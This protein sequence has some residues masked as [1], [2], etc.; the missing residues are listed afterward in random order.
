MLGFLFRLTRRRTS[1][2]RSGYYKRSSYQIST[3]EQTEKSAAL[4]GNSIRENMHDLPNAQ[5]RKIIDGDTV[6]VNKAGSLIKVRLD[7]IDCPEDG[8]DWG[9]NAKYGLIKLIGGRSVK[10]EEH[11]ADH[12]GRLLATIY[13]QE[14]DDDNGGWLNVNEKMVTRGH[15]WVMRLFYDHLPKDRQ[16]KLNSLEKWAKSKKIGLWGKPD[17]I[18]PWNWRKS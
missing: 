4:D 9:D 1:Y 6:V 7:A 5:V 11:G 15:A 12:H 8:Q 3:L 10:L 18:P 14:E 13:V 17:P 2:R 16:N